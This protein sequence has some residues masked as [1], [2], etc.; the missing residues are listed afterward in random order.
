M[1]EMH[2]EDE[3]RKKLEMLAAIKAE[4]ARVEAFWGMTAS[5]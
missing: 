5:T 4:T 1:A 2:S 3:E